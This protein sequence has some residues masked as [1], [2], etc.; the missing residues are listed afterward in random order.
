MVFR[1]FSV[2]PEDLMQA[3][4]MRRRNVIAD[5]PV[6]FTDPPPYRYRD[7]REES[8]VRDSVTQMVQRP[9]PD[10][11]YDED[12][13]VGADI[14]RPENAVHVRD[15]YRGAFQDFA[16]NPKEDQP[17]YYPLG[18]ERMERDP[19]SSG[20][21]S[22]LWWSAQVTL[23]SLSRNVFDPL[24]G[25]GNRILATGM[26]AAMRDINGQMGR[27][28]FINDLMK[29][30][31]KHRT[32]GYD[33]PIREEL[34]PEIEETFDRF[35]NRFLEIVPGSEQDALFSAFHALHKRTYPGMPDLTPEMQEHRERELL[36]ER[37]IDYALSSTS[38][39][40]VVSWALSGEGR[41]LWGDRDEIRKRIET[42]PVY[43]L[44]D[45]WQ[46]GA[47]LVGFSKHAHVAMTLLNRK[48]LDGSTGLP[49][50]DALLFG[51]KALYNI[52]PLNALRV[53]ELPFDV[54][55]S[56]AEAARYL[57]SEQL[58]RQQ[59]GVEMT[60]QVQWTLQGEAY[61]ADHD[62][63]YGAQAKLDF[64]SPIEWFIPAEKVVTKPLGLGFKY[65]KARGA[66]STLGKNIKGVASFRSR[67]TF[68][69]V[70]RDP[71]T[72]YD[73]GVTINDVKNFGTPADFAAGGLGET[74][75]LTDSSGI[76]GSPGSATGQN[77]S[78]LT[79][80][81]AE[82]RYRSLQADALNVNSENKLLHILKSPIRAF[83]RKASP[84]IGSRLTVDRGA[85]IAR[86]TDELRSR[87][88]AESILFAQK[89]QFHLVNDKTRGVVPTFSQ[90]SGDHPV[91]HINDDGIIQNLPSPVA[92][93]LGDSQ[94]HVFENLYHQ[95]I[96]DANF[97]FSLHKYAPDMYNFAQR[98]KSSLA[99]FRELIHTWDLD[100]V[101]DSLFGPNGSPFVVWKADGTITDPSIWLQTRLT[102]AQGK[103]LK[104]LSIKDMI[105]D[106]VSFLTPDLADGTLFNF[107]VQYNASLFELEQIQRLIT[108]VYGAGTLDESGMKAVLRAY[109]DK[110]GSIGAVLVD[111]RN[112]RAARAAEEARSSDPPPDAPPSAGPPSDSPPPDAPPSDPS[113]VPE[114]EPVPPVQDVVGASG[115]R[116]RVTN[117]ER[118]G[119]GV[120]VE[121]ELIETPD[122]V[123]DDVLIDP[124]N[125]IT[126]VADAAGEPFIKES[127]QLGESRSPMVDGASSYIDAQSVWQVDP[128]AR[129]PL[130]AIKF[131]ASNGFM[132]SIEIMSSM[133][134]AAKNKLSRAIHDDFTD[135][136]V[137]DLVMH[138]EGHRAVE[139]RVWGVIESLD[140]AFHDV[141]REVITEY[142]RKQRLALLGEDVD[143]TYPEWD[144]AAPRSIPDEVASDVVPEAP[145]PEAVVDETIT[146]PLDDVVEA[147]VTPEVPPVAETPARPAVPK[148]IR[149]VQGD[150]LE[151]TEVD[152]LVNPVNSVGAMGKGLAKQFR[153]KYRGTGYYTGYKDAVFAGKLR[154][155]MLRYFKVGRQY[156]VDFPTKYRWQNPSQM[157]YIIDGL[158]TL[159][160]TMA[161]RGIHSIAIPGLGSG[162]GG[163]HWPDVKEEILK[164]LGDIDVEIVVYEPIN[165]PKVAPLSRPAQ[166]VP[167]PQAP[168]PPA[169]AAA[170]PELAPAPAAPEPAPVAPDVP[171]DPPALSVVS[172]TVPEGEEP[173]YIWDRVQNQF[174]EYKPVPGDLEIVS[175]PEMVLG[176]L[177]DTSYA[178][179]EM[180]NQIVRKYKHPSMMVGTHQQRLPV[181]FKEITD[182]ISGRFPQDKLDEM[183]SNVYATR[184][185]IQDEVF[186]VADYIEEIFYRMQGLDGIDPQK[187]V[188]KPREKILDRI[189]TYLDLFDKERLAPL[190]QLEWVNNERRKPSVS[191]E[192]QALFDFVFAPEKGFPAG[193][194]FVSKLP[195]AV[196]EHIAKNRAIRETL[197][198][199][200]TLRGR[201]MRLN[202]EHDDLLHY[203][204]NIDDPSEVVEELRFLD[205]ARRA[206]PQRKTA[207]SVK[208]AKERG[209][210]RQNQEELLK[211]RQAQQDALEKDLR[212]GHDSNAPDDDFV[213]EKYTAAGQ[214]QFVES[215]FVTQ[216]QISYQQARAGLDPA[217]QIEDLERLFPD[218][219][220]DD[221]KSRLEEWIELVEDFYRPVIDEKRLI[222]LPVFQYDFRAIAAARPAFLRRAAQDITAAF[223][224]AYSEL[225]S[226]TANMVSQQELIDTGNVEKGLLDHLLSQSSLDDFDVVL[227]SYI[228]KNPGLDQLA[229]AIAGLRRRH[230]EEL[231]SSL[232]TQAKQSI[233][234]EL[235]SSVNA[236]IS[237]AQRLY[238][239]RLEPLVRRARASAAEA[240][241][242]LRVHNE[243]FADKSV[244][245]SFETLDKMNEP[246]S[247]LLRYKA[248]LD[249]RLRFFTRVR[250]SQ[251]ESVDDIFGSYY[252]AQED[253]L[254]SKISHNLADIE[255]QEN[256]IADL[257]HAYMPD[258]APAS[259]RVKDEVQTQVL[260][261]AELLR[262][263]REDFATS[264]GLLGDLIGQSI[265]DVHLGGRTLV[266]LL[267]RHGIPI[268]SR[269]DI[270][271]TWHIDPDILH[272]LT[273][274]PEDVLRE[275]DRQWRAEYSLRMANSSVDRRVSF[276]EYGSNPNMSFFDSKEWLESV[277]G[278]QRADIQASSNL[279]GSRKDAYSTVYGE[280]IDKTG[281]TMGPELRGDQPSGGRPVYNQET[282]KW[283]TESEEMMVAGQSQKFYRPGDRGLAYS[284]Y[285]GHHSFEAADP[286]RA[287]YAET[288]RYSVNSDMFKPQLKPID[289][290]YLSK[291]LESLPGDRRA[292]PIEEGD[293]QQI[294]NL[295]S[296]LQSV[297]A[298]LLSVAKR[299]LDNAGA[300]ALVK[301]SDSPDLP[302]GIRDIL[303]GVDAS[304]KVPPFAIFGL[305][306]TLNNNPSSWGRVLRAMGTDPDLQDTFG[307]VLGR[308]ITAQK[309]LSKV[310]PASVEE[311][312]SKFY[313]SPAR[314]YEPRAVPESPYWGWDSGDM[315]PVAHPRA[316]TM[317]A[318]SPALPLMEIEDLPGPE[319]GVYDTAVDYTGVPK[320]GGPRL[321]KGVRAGAEPPEGEALPNLGFRESWQS[322]VDSS[323]INRFNDDTR[324][325]FYQD[326]DYFGKLSP[327]AK[328]PI[329]L[330]GSFNAQIFV[331]NLMEVY[332]FFKWSAHPGI[333]QEIAAA[334]GGNNA[335]KTSLKYQK[336]YGPQNIDPYRGMYY[337]AR[338]LLAQHF[339]RLAPLLREARYTPEGAKKRVHML[340]S[341]SFWGSRV[342][343]VKNEI[344]GTNL[345]GRIWER[346]ADE[347]HIYGEDALRAVPPPLI[348]VSPLERVGLGLTRR[349]RPGQLNPDGSIK[350]P[351]LV[352]MG[353]GLAIDRWVGNSDKSIYKNEFGNT[354]EGLE[355][356]RKMVAANRASWNPAA[357]Q[358]R[359]A[360]AEAFSLV[361]MKQRTN[362]W[363]KPI[364]RNTRWGNKF[365]LRDYGG[366]R[367][368]VV[369]LY[370][371]A[372][373]EK[374]GTGE[375]TRQDLIDLVTGPDGKAARLS[376]HCAPKLCHGYVLMRYGMAAKLGDDA[377]ERMM[378]SSTVD[379][380]NRLPSDLKNPTN[381]PRNAP[382][383]DDQSLASMAGQRLGYSY[384]VEGAADHFEILKEAIM[385]AANK[386]NTLTSD[387]VYSPIDN[388]RKVAST[389]AKYS[390]Q[391]LNTVI[392]DAEE[393]LVSSAAKRLWQ[394]V[395]VPLK[396]AEALLTAFGQAAEE[397]GANPFRSATPYDASTLGESK[398]PSAILLGGTGARLEERFLADV[399]R[400][401]LYSPSEKGDGFAAKTVAENLARKAGHV[402]A[403]QQNTGALSG[404]VNA[405]GVNGTLLTRLA[406]GPRVVGG[407]TYVS[408]AGGKFLSV[409]TSQGRRTGALMFAANRHMP[410]L[411]TAGDWNTLADTARALLMGNQVYL[412]RTENPL[413][414]DDLFAQL[415]QSPMNIGDKDTRVIEML[416]AIVLLGRLSP[417]IWQASVWRNLGLS[418]EALAVFDD[419]S[420]STSDEYLEMFSDASLVD[421]AN[422]LGGFSEPTLAFGNNVGS[423]ENTPE[424]H[425]LRLRSLYRD[426][427]DGTMAGD[428]VTVLGRILQH[429]GRLPTLTDQM[430]ALTGSSSPRLTPSPEGTG[431]AT[432]WQLD[433]ALGPRKQTPQAESLAD[434]PTPPR[435]SDESNAFLRD[436]TSVVEVAS[437][438]LR[439]AAPSM[440]QRQPGDADSIMSGGHIVNSIREFLRPAMLYRGEVGPTGERL[441]PTSTRTGGYADRMAVPGRRGLDASVESKK[442]SDTAP[443]PLKE[444]KS[445]R[446]RRLQEW[447]MLAG[448]TS[449]LVPYGD[450]PGVQMQ[451]LL[452]V[453]TKARLGGVNVME[454]PVGVA[455]VVADDAEAIA[456][457]LDTPVLFDQL[458]ASDVSLARYELK[459]L[460]DELRLIRFRRSPSGASTDIP[461]DIPPRTSPFEDVS[462]E[463]VVSD[464]PSTTPSPPPDEPS[465]SGDP[466]SDFMSY[467]D[468]MP[469]DEYDIDFSHQKEKADISDGSL[470]DLD[471]EIATLEAERATLREN[472]SRIEDALNRGI[473]DTINSYEAAKARAEKAGEKLIPVKERESR[474]LFERNVVMPEQEYKAWAKYRTH[475]TAADMGLE[476]WHKWVTDPVLRART[477]FDSS[478]Y[479][480]QLGH[481]MFSRPADVPH[482]YRKMIS[483]F[484]K[485]D[486]FQQF[487]IDNEDVVSD[488]ANYGVQIR[489]SEVEVFRRPGSDYVASASGRKTA[490]QDI[491]DFGHNVLDQESSELFAKA[492]A[493]GVGALTG[494][495]RRFQSVYD[496]IL[497]RYNTEEWIAQKPAV[498]ARAQ[499]QGLDVDAEL[500]AFAQS[501]N[502]QSLLMSN[503]FSGVT[504]RGNAIR[505]LVL[506]A[507]AQALSGLTLIADVFKKGPNA[508]ASR[509]RLASGV[510]A[511][512]LFYTLAS[513]A[514]GQ[515]P[516]LNPAP[517]ED[518]GDGA[519]FLTI[520]VGDKRIGLQSGVMW[521]LRLGGGLV[522][523]ALSWDNPVGT[524]AS[525]VYDRMSPTALL[526]YQF[527]K[528]RRFDGTAIDNF[529]DKLEEV[530]RNYVPFPVED[531]L[532]DADARNG[533]GLLA[534]FID[535]FGGDVRDV[536]L[537]VR[538]KEEQ[539]RLADRFYDRPWSNIGLEKRKN[540]MVSPESDYLHELLEEERQHRN[541]SAVTDYEKANVSRSE[542]MAQ[543]TNT[544]V[545]DF[546]KSDLDNAWREDVPYGAGSPPPEKRAIKFLRVV[547]ADTLMVQINGQATRIRLKDV[548][549]PEINP[550]GDTYL[551][552]VEKDD[553]GRQVVTAFMASEQ[554]E[555]SLLTTGDVGAHG[556]TLGDIISPSGKSLQEHL[557]EK[558][559]AEQA[560]DYYK[561]QA[562]KDMT[563]LQKEFYYNGSLQ[564]KEQVH[565]QTRVREMLGHLNRYYY[566]R[567]LIMDKY[568]AYDAQREQ[569]IKEAWER[570]PNDVGVVGQRL[571]EA[572]IDEVLTNPKLLAHVEDG[573]D[574]PH[575]L[576]ISLRENFAN[577]WG[578]EKLNYVDALQDQFLHTREFTPP[579]LLYEWQ[580]GL[581]IFSEY[582]QA[583]EDYA[584][585]NAHEYDLFDKEV[586]RSKI[587]EYAALSEEGKKDFENATDTGLTG[588]RK[589]NADYMK[590]IDLKRRVLKGFRMREDSDNGRDFD[591]FGYRMGWWDK[592]INPQ[593]AHTD[594]QNHFSFSSSIK[595]PPYVY[596]RV[597]YKDTTLSRGQ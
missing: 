6:N 321:D 299:I 228:D 396:T 33:G 573:A 409:P 27:E 357:G 546:I 222:P 60:P 168:A 137:R 55:A 514:T 337:S 93:L 587:R 565:V 191:S 510:M 539:N 300:G 115:S 535:F 418:E 75:S 114:E 494:F 305:I 288:A 433:V 46:D 35:Y 113:S 444:I 65:F 14:E 423:F 345:M 2:R 187:W 529:G 200:E 112:R 132:K 325:G 479:T 364:D 513:F 400:R 473:D 472:I 278:L 109:R 204:Q 493:S 9:L 94:Y 44:Y 484:G 253:S 488:M 244:I 118:E 92:D 122:V 390:S 20:I 534:S 594:Y 465:V 303:S 543:I 359:S 96:V 15:L 37:Q 217:R 370:Q 597:P 485:P 442:Y 457:I 120:A 294:V 332:E 413:Q 212:A 355:K 360:T 386:V 414:I 123:P 282:G 537:S 373:N 175:S 311:L 173:W 103:A 74:Y 378:G 492:W 126:L 131:S 124:D 239:D 471:E 45:D 452:D 101:F 32:Y 293:L 268:L 43:A 532:F 89:M 462:P 420:R 578:E 214:S 259:Q 221:W 425:D 375:V 199:V 23:D 481:L 133:I 84:Y 188:A 401:K 369:N 489:P 135:N 21:L 302:T 180:Y 347:I 280:S 394:H 59:A 169:P 82:K 430:E 182:D 140:A 297:E 219:R 179:K 445:R 596:D 527:V 211:E 295:S 340:G 281:Q 382:G 308:Y 509:R 129:M 52:F 243:A 17:I 251:V 149:F 352:N 478:V 469:L 354:P 562:T 398:L 262:Q 439:D 80:E 410:V 322:K 177:S 167:A 324:S 100:D 395:L 116:I 592:A 206:K 568:E 26:S 486:I 271:D 441:M 292:T 574:Y 157:R 225:K 29:E 231:S 380:Y 495:S 54:Y 49:G 451:H 209:I 158:E 475:G 218:L 461:D 152:A 583:A 128:S 207:E 143:V 561:E 62:F 459:R 474:F 117:V 455:K 291:Q 517:K 541:A 119:F 476:A 58:V 348:N 545:N 320:T 421:Q 435:F 436:A 142:W 585:E 79:R 284:D 148:N 189:Y 358:K 575:H 511:G 440:P 531:L 78:K 174:V 165:M 161:D 87:G 579:N 507:P 590:A 466:S 550:K 506:F 548:N 505:R 426:L 256:Y 91:F 314:K 385:D 367:E 76:Y 83:S 125:P 540:I 335:S 453:T 374:I 389:F 160:R 555:Y 4:N 121:Y 330:P 1:D 269:A 30:Y 265:Q 551:T 151:N 316:R 263:A 229:T 106:G 285:R 90:K 88:N 232:P 236:S 591:M 71:G 327:F 499:E 66:A 437:D 172:D 353:R 197:N 104:F 319:I 422:E 31:P 56:Q 553:L 589:I 227:Q 279:A 130:E 377:L 490:F 470:E 304:K 40:R 366:N 198:F 480:D 277:M 166:P 153:D 183:W 86:A 593:T 226:A 419:L 95:F 341:D 313:E 448:R 181:A 68:D 261:S 411:A 224:A 372:L 449:R 460:S 201:V 107:L 240:Y 518:G 349:L 450:Y 242:E 247:K 273:N 47:G 538:K 361:V 136:F 586:V 237:S 566:Q 267:K 64:L 39:E 50:L 549:A 522:H 356:Y 512:L 53:L 286:S 381:T 254:R 393:S 110:S 576:Y 205:Y 150:I 569:E 77:Y 3:A 343:F 443:E 397:V 588:G 427:G 564:I 238:S 220:K 184:D 525:S 145:V 19:E 69:S 403:I 407:N 346:I 195:A 497:V 363:T 213:D 41:R 323:Q 406:E 234:R 536:S 491:A 63:D 146:E 498:I 519:D 333:Q 528:Q 438:R 350:E 67:S 296:D 379:W 10:T 272:A 542:E 558:G 255:M 307:R 560:L 463:E 264:K 533:G 171:D 99:N 344:A 326:S 338:V 38:G 102:A 203:Q 572:Y 329:L 434:Q 464:S 563:A 547:D 18:A 315:G 417:E 178:A 508:A 72:P 73:N 210:E 13:V 170:A 342:D 25:F 97:R 141:P 154:P 504:P 159:K 496:M 194:K 144:E 36:I 523:D 328:F 193:P 34:R 208:S 468:S 408:E 477:A 371:K 42:D 318:R 309:D 257:E 249:A 310:L 11:S 446:Q 431:A 365:H 428:F 554:G 274:M 235:L 312:R 384:K 577:K 246:L 287:P 559:L 241:E 412:A 502:R 196:S 215:Q 216:Q 458:K 176:K 526:P 245:E 16:V 276:P 290:K 24:A 415:K 387:T 483:T 520:R 185:I 391:D 248:E 336:K 301:L 223:A 28:S 70:G 260:G 447:Q 544:L 556:R 81:S 334:G 454:D 298:Q 567:Q 581:R 339:E 105:D 456:K 155:G 8:V 85:N 266:E 12:S 275:I 503:T 416:E 402:T 139:G 162:L 230:G 501:L 570:N 7:P 530:G 147:P 108:D 487:L 306:D 362:D 521:M 134:S 252:K 500:T 111:L 580:H 404:L 317:S 233:L 405:R 258:S 51:A 552:D 186:R 399:V 250:P 331:E 515:T 283:E 388:P 368:T 429:D 595:G 61:A 383:W 163:L 351:V 98:R 270:T 524:I 584:V 392:Y 156:I 424:L 127:V 516:K 138:P 376:C 582:F 164:R 571:R 467:D 48:I 192:A 5:T 202:S 432:R 557:V 22:D 190:N 57:H 289:W 482:Y